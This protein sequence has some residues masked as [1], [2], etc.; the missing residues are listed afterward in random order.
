MAHE[1]IRN[2][3]SRTVE[4]QVS[5][6]HGLC[7]ERGRL[8]W[9]GKSCCDLQHF[10]DDLAFA[11]GDSAA[12]ATAAFAPAHVAAATWIS[13]LLYSHKIVW[14]IRNFSSC[15]RLRPSVEVDHPLRRSPSHQRNRPV[16]RIQ[17][18][19]RIPAASRRSLEK[20]QSNLFKEP[21]ICVG[22]SSQNPLPEERPR[23]NQRR[24]MLSIVAR[25]TGGLF[26]TPITID[27]I[28][29]SLLAHTHTHT[30]THTRIGSGHWQLIAGDNAARFARL[31]ANC[32]QIIYDTHFGSPLL[33]FFG[34]DKLPYLVWH[35]AI[36]NYVYSV[37]RLIIS[38][39]DWLT[40]MAFTSGDL[41]LKRI[42]V[43]ASIV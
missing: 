38:C 27:A 13:P 18:A 22:G 11:R 19:S 2:V 37:W 1:V 29:F 43:I 4:K 33:F 35:Y 20:C 42:E 23:K 6:G 12:T 3:W 26:F 10:Y 16:L 41:W 8:R 28:W 32:W 34:L 36:M 30:N 31:L 17:S 9:C 14:H 25:S 40:L 7:W 24:Q 39:H 21:R 15:P 5:L